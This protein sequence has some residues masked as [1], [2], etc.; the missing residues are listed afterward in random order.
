MTAEWKTSCM[1][2]PAAPAATTASPAPAKASPAP[3][4]SSNSAGVN[5]LL[6]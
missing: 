4:S 2:T 3:A 6:D 1:G 5:A